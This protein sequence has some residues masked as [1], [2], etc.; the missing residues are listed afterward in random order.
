VLI[1]YGEGE[2]RFKEVQLVDFGSTVHMDY[3]HARDGAGL[4]FSEARRL[5]YR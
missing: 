5:I 1:N 4:Q 2:S 3:A